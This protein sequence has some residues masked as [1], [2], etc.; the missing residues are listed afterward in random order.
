MLVQGLAGRGRLRGAGNGEVWAG[1]G[2]RGGGGSRE[3]DRRKGAQVE[4][5]R[6][7]GAVVIKKVFW[8]NQK[9]EYFIKDE[10]VFHTN[11]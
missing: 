6:T 5:C 3:E 2:T 4:R 10:A 11:T 7:E 8:S 1:Q 9:Y